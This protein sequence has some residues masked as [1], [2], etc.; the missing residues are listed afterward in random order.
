M[1][2]HIRHPSDIPI[3]VTQLGYEELATE[4]LKDVSYGGLSFHSKVPILL[5]KLIE[6]HISVV[7]PRFEALA[8]VVWCEKQESYFEIGVELDN[9]DAAF[10]VRMIEQICHIEHYKHQVLSEQGRH[11]SG[12]EAAME[13]ISKYADTFPKIDEFE[14]T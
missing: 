7:E 6:I 13:W 14:S 1:R 12:A 9:Q 11:L 4:S 8:K 3:E 10:R 5:G 2:K